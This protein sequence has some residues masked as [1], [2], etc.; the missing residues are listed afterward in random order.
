M[1]LTAR[2]TNP[3]ALDSSSQYALLIVCL[4]ALLITYVE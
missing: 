2:I 4:S 3:L 1:P